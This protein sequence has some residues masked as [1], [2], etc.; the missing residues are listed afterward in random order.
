MLRFLLAM[1]AVR[2][3][4]LFLPAVFLSPYMIKYNFLHYF[5]PFLLTA[6]VIPSLLLGNPFSD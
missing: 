4:M 5:F 6:L 3:R 2:A 1:R